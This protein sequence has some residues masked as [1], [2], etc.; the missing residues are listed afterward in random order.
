MTE[1]ENVTPAESTPAE[2]TTEQTTETETATEQSEKPARVKKGTISYAVNLTT[3]EVRAYKGLPIFE[4]GKEV[5]VLEKAHM[6]RI[7]TP[8]LVQLYNKVRPE[9]PIQK[10]RDRKAAESTM[11]PVLE[12]LGGIPQPGAG[13][14]MPAAAKKS[15]RK[16]ATKK[17]A[18]KKESNG[19]AGRTSAF[20][21][22][23]ITKLVK[24]NPRREGTFGFKS[25]ALIK[26]G[27]TYE[28]YLEAGGRRNDLAWDVEHKYVE[29]K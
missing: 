24:D 17:V 23:K 4:V 18:A 25:F 28:A 16:T 8:V 11:Y 5:A 15:G 12:L 3:H 22:K 9:R 14:T 13:K 29:V 10:F 26:N 19:A 27:M 6:S 20:A 2:T 21:G 1:N 7:P